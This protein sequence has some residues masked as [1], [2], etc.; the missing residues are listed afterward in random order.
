MAAA[1]DTGD[2]AV[3]VTDLAQAERVLATLR[4][5]D[6]DPS[7]RA[8]TL[9]L[10]VYAAAQPEVE[11]ALR[12]IEEIGGSRPLRAIVASAAQ[13]GGPRARLSTSCF[14]EAGAHRVW[15]SEQI[16]LETRREALASAVL[17]LLLSDLPLFLWWQG[18]TKSGGRTMRALAQEASRLIVNSDEC[19]LVRLAELDALPA[20]LTDLAWTRLTPW[21]E[22]LARMFDAPTQRAALGRIQRLEVQGPENQAA[23]LAGWLRSRLAHTVHLHHRDAARMELAVIS[24]GEETF[25]VRRSGDDHGV[26]AA[27]G[28]PEKAVLLEE[29]GAGLLLAAELD[30][31]GRD[32]VFE[33]ALA[34]AREDW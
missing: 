3:D 5:R 8:T 24:C 22:A 27:P 11:A 7:F 15:C 26:M 6:G 2:D 13:D 21:R 9:N 16:V 20:A 19:G 10:V 34:A 1:V 17:S 29:P 28:V 4:A 33:Q 14:G 32:E 12:A 18:D 25:S 23:L 30:V 31:F